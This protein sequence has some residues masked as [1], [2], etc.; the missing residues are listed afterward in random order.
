M[1][2]DP[3]AV[4]PLI[5]ALKNGDEMFRECAARV[6]G[7]IGDPQAVEALVGAL[8]DEVGDVQRRA[9]EALVLIGQTAFDPLILA[10]SDSNSDVRRWVAQ[11]LGEIG[12]PRAVEP[13]TCLASRD[14]ESSVRE[15]ATTALKKLAG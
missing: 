10:L 14:E 8:T 3:G 6:L 9:A 7:M 5:D 2:G 15:A 13:L 11:A 1:I 12:D 4:D